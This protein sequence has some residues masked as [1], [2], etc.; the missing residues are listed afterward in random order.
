MPEEMSVLTSQIIEKCPHYSWHIAFIC[1][2]KLRADNFS[3][4]FMFFFFRFDS[5]YGRPVS[6]CDVFRGVV[7]LD[8]IVDVFLHNHHIL[9]VSVELIA[10][11]Y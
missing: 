4:V 11:S 10:E 1:K 6:L 8:R 9:V 3:V 2:N 7:H 5:R